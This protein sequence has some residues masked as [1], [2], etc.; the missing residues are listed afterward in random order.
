[1]KTTHFICARFSLS[2][3]EFVVTKTLHFLESTTEK[4]K[5]SLV[6]TDFPLF[7]FV[8]LVKRGFFF[9]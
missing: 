1:M 8:D 5:T 9:D 3:L 6:Q 2:P 7:L 4:L